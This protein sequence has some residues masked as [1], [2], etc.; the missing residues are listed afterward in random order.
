[1]SDWFPLR[2]WA[3]FFAVCVVWFCVTIAYAPLIAGW[4]GR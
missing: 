3:R 4:V 2:F 1:M